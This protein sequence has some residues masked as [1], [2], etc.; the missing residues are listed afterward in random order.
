MLDCRLERVQRR[1]WAH[2]DD[3]LSA[4]FTHTFC[5]V[6]H[7]SFNTHPL[8]CSS[9]A[10]FPH[11]PLKMRTHKYRHA[12]V[13][14]I[15]FRNDKWNVFRA[16]GWLS[17]AVRSCVSELTFLLEINNREQRRTSSCVRENLFSVMSQR[18]G[19]VTHPLWD[20]MIYTDVCKT[21]RI[22]GDIILQTRFA[23]S[24]ERKF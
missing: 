14:W 17:L 12:A 5:C 9:G 6:P 19:G 20:T 7:A 13:H 21:S 8:S 18:C 16:S 10:R 11:T 4:S 22:T 15:W 24:T 1:W 2:G 3:R 23:P